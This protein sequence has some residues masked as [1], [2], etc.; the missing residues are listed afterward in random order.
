M[1]ARM[2]FFFTETLI[3]LGFDNKII[4]LFMDCASSAR[5]QIS[6]GGKEFGNI[7]PERGI[8]QE[9]PLS[10]YLFLIC[11]EGLTT[12]IDP[13]LLKEGL[14][15]GVKVARGAPTLSHMFFADDSYIF[16]QAI[17]IMTM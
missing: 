10:S 2:E 5:Y 14:I 4:E 13:K 3:K 15:Q 9:D 6:H 16:Y 17:K 1:N 11:L 12:Y 8:R 7:M